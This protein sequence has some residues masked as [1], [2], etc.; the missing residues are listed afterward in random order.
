MR[1]SN[2]EGGQFEVRKEYCYKKEKSQGKEHLTADRMCHLHEI[3]W[4]D[5][6]FLILKTFFTPGIKCF[7]CDWIAMR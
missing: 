4:R 2:R 7:F 1:C 5:F 3:G 6:S